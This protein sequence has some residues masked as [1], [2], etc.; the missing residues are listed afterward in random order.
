MPG[1]DKP[2]T[3]CTAFEEGQEFI[4]DDSL[5]QAGTLVMCGEVAE[6]AARIDDSAFP[7]QLVTYYKRFFGYAAAS[8]IDDS[9]FPL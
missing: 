1:T 2:Y 7:L 9:A 6:A 4:V 3:K 5:R 8:W